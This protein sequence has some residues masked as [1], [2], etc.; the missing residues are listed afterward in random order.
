[1]SD[2]VDLTLQE[3]RRTPFIYGQSDCMLSIGRYIALCGGL[4]LTGQFVGKYD[5]HEGA[6]DVLR[7]GGGV[8]GYVEAAGFVRVDD[9]P[10]RG[11]VVG[12]QCNDDDEIGALCT[13][14]MIAARLE[15][16]VVEVAAKMLR[17]KGVWRV[18][19]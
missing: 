12:L 3:W 8:G 6:L 9:E 17:V 1:M 15:R 10:R 13:G 16:G 19:S 11:D 7:N 5:D 2:L 4:D 14:G 18:R